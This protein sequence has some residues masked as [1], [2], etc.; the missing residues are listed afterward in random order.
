M[1]GAV[2]VSSL[3]GSV[4]RFGPWEMCVVPY[5][6]FTELNELLRVLRK[7]TECI[8]MNNGTT[9]I[10]MVG[11]CDSYIVE[12]S[13]LFKCSGRLVVEGHSNPYQERIGILTSVRSSTANL[14]ITAITD[15]DSDD[16]VMH[17]RY[18]YN[19]Q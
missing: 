8:L 14:S 19:R 2:G 5:L 17:T 6:V 3:S 9:L 13:S 16:I 12:L 4:M 1:A 10:T 7:L 15:S 18:N 11:L